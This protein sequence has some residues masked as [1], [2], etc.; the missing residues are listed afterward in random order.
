MPNRTAGLAS[1]RG[2]LPALL[3][4]LVLAAA[5]LG[6]YRALTGDDD[7][8]R[9]GR[10]AGGPPTPTAGPTGPRDG[11]RI[12]PAPRLA[13]AG[14]G[15]TYRITAETAVRVGTGTTPQ[16]Q[17]PEVRRIAEQLAAQ[18]RRSTG[19]PLPVTEHPGASGAATG[20]LLTLDP[21][22]PAE[23]GPEGYRLTAGGE[24][25]VISARTG[26]GLYRGT[27]TL[28]QLL[29]P[30]IESAGPVAGRTDWEVAPVEIEDGPRYAY[31]GV[32]LDVARHFFTV[33]EV[34]GFIDR[35]ALYKVNRLHLH[36]TDDQGWRIAIP[37]L[38]KLTEV[39]AVGEVGG[40]PGGFYT[41]ADYGE[42]V[43]Y[44]Q[45]RY[46]TVV[47]EIDLPGHTNAAL[48]S[49]P[50]LDC[51]DTRRPAPYTGIDVGFSL[52][53][54][55]DERTFAFTAT[56]IDEVARLTPGEY[57]HIGGDEVK[58]LDAAGYQAFG[59]RIAAQV[60]AA[61]KKPV[62]WN[63]YAPAAGPDTVPLLQYWDGDAQNDQDVAAAVR[64][65]AK[66]IMSPAS[67]TYLDMKYDSTYDLG[68]R[69]AG[70]I[71]VYASYGWDPDTE[72]RELPAGSVYGVEAP[73][74]TE[75]L[76]TPAELDRMLLP[77]MPAIAELGW[78]DKAA[79]SWPRF[80]ERLAE[81]GP[82]WEAAGFGYERRVEVPWR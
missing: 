69:W 23:A 2:G 40:S 3:V 32:L 67:R 59:R 19:L 41:A 20:I 15:G 37:G 36:L 29:P 74:W 68:L 4:V 52:I 24:R 57:L 8:D 1:R 35:L 51:R 76:S 30:Q 11:S 70:T 16:G 82:R 72:K 50:E 10:A 78:S 26:A 56:V 27:Q 71:D 80:R 66:V 17:A 49:Y 45:D 64:R 12:I 79:H 42:I 62:G 63:Q 5:A 65:G 54:P 44:A 14:H 34:K 75:T 18:L 6:S 21:A 48:A 81:E 31:R 58:K 39:G 43:R 77:R 13:R 33:A 9:G 22:L 60:I 38:P 61:G 46:I 25:V 47:P 53:C 28:R 55:D 7:G 73:L